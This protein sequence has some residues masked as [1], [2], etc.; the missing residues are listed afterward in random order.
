M[1][2]ALFKKMHFTVLSFYAAIFIF[3]VCGLF[4]SMPV[5][6]I[7]VLVFFMFVADVYFIGVFYSTKREKVTLSTRSMAYFYYK[8]SFVL[9]NII[10]IV[11]FIL[12]ILTLLVVFNIVSFNMIVSKSIKTIDLFTYTYPSLFF[13]YIT[14][15]GQFFY[16]FAKKYPTVFIARILSKVTLVI[17]LLLTTTCM[18]VYINLSSKVFSKVFTTQNALIEE[19]TYSASMTLSEYLED[20]YNDEERALAFSAFSDT[21]NIKEIML[22]MGNSLYKSPDNID[23]YKKHFIFD[24]LILKSDEFILVLTGKDYSNVV[25]LTIIIFIAITSFILFPLI[26]LSQKLMED[27][28]ASAINIMVDG[29]HLQGSNIAID[30]TD[31]KDSEILEMCRGYNNNFLALKYRDLY[32]SDIKKREIADE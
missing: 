31:M 21:N 3:T 6:L 28:I 12:T 18:V 30:T 9:K 27:N 8:A 25:Y 29:F 1:N 26:L 20:R 22:R 24:M 19:L 14:R 17:F 16:Y 32:M 15:I 23:F 11:P 7:K 10:T 2:N 5:N 4:L 13:I